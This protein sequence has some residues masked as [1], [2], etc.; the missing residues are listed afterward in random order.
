MHKYTHRPALTSLPKLNRIILAKNVKNVL[1]VQP[2]PKDNHLYGLWLR[3]RGARR[4]RGACRAPRMS[5]LACEAQ[6]GFYCPAGTAVASSPAFIGHVSGRNIAVNVFSNMGN[7]SNM[8]GYSHV[9]F[10]EE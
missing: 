10:G 6:G 1:R 8:F 7:L 2:P 9:S 4:L 3:I 5:V